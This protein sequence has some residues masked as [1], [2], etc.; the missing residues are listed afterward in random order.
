MSV[1]I[2]MCHY[3]H[4]S[5]FP[6]P[7]LFPHVGLPMLVTLSSSSLC[8]KRYFVLTLGGSFVVST[9]YIYIC[10]V[11]KTYI[12]VLFF[13]V[14]TLFLESMRLQPCLWTNTYFNILFQ[15]NPF[16]SNSA[17]AQQIQKLSK[18]HFAANPE[19]SRI[20]HDWFLYFSCGPEFC[21]PSSF[22]MIF[23]YPLRT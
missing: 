19:L 20:A 9:A 10:T 15:A 21:F 13:M 7:S 11:R 6:C 14:M 2:S 18:V 23:S 22:N 17:G 16:I 1:T 12:F 5:L 4:V 8:V 3:F